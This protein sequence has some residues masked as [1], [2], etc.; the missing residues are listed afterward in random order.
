[1]A[2]DEYRVRQWL[3]QERPLLRELLLI[4][5]ASLVVGIF[6][7]EHVHSTLAH[8]RHEAAEA[9]AQQLASTSAEYV[10]TG[11]MV[12]LNVIAGHA[13]RL[14]TVSRVEFRS[15]AGNV[16]A[17]AGPMQE[18]E[19][20]VSRAVRLEDQSVA[21]NVEL[22]PADTSTRQEKN[23]E[24]NFVLVVICLLALRVLG[25]VVWRRLQV[26][27]EEPEEV[28]ADM[29]P[30][31]SMSQTNDP[32]KALLRISIVNFD[33]MQERL[34]SGLIEEM[35]A[36]YRSALE[37]IA[38]VYGARV[39]QTLGKQCA[40][41]IR[42]ESRAEAAFQA[43]CAGMLF[44]RLARSITEQRKQQGRT[45]LEFKLLV[46]CAANIEASWSMCVA[47]LP[48]RVHVPESE[49]EK[50]ELD[51]RLLYQADRCLEVSNGETILRLQPIEQLA[52]RYQK[53]IADQA[54]T[55]TGAAASS[56]TARS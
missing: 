37:G 22:W 17:S 51:A 46:T 14:P 26:E 21:G 23:L 15:V 24:S 12:S 3:H 41:E 39:V 19:A 31:L 34:T 13:A 2:W 44:R 50:M 56:V 28:D 48:G 9:L 54:A 29:V 25:E 45:P 6:F 49:L 20:P 40:L 53:L 38:G 47:G 5:L 1:M 35:V 42:A 4:L 16:L 43:L 52:Q 55:L 33:R 36:S 32:P 30:V 11:N 27:R 18:A 10:V 7:L 8:N